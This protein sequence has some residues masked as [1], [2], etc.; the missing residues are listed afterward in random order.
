MSRRKLLIAGGLLA[1]GAYVYHRGLRFPRMGFTPPPLA[2]QVRLSNADVSFK[3]LIVN[4]SAAP[5]QPRFR[6]H[7]PEP[8]LTV[9][10]SQAPLTLTIDNIAQ[11]AV[12]NVQGL[13]AQL[14]LDEDIRGLQRTIRLP[15]SVAAEVTLRWEWPDSEQVRFAVIG[16]SGGLQELDWCLQRAA[17][18]NT[19]FLLHMGDFNYSEGE[20]DLAIEKFN[21]AQIPV[22]VSIGNHDFNQSGLIYQQFLDE[23]A[24]LNHSFI[25]A[26]SRFTNLDTAADFFPVSTGNRGRLLHS[27]LQ[28]QTEVSDHVAFSHS[29]FKDT[30]PG[31][32]HDI[33]GGG[34]IA[35]L[36]DMLSQLGVEDYLC[37]HVHRSSEIETHG[38]RQWI[39]GE[40]LGFEDIRNK[41]KVAQILLGE[42]QVGKKIQY[43]W[44]P[45]EMPWHLQHSPTHIEK[46]KKEL[47]ASMLEWYRQKTRL[48]ES[49]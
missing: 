10:G 45:L 20:Y 40:G 8:L 44:A 15:A 34:E 23:I 26:G 36:A 14:S 5:E 18:L 27:L 22:Y 32:D 11:H 7:E 49:G 16:D 6:A 2:N 1:G 12:L 42:A 3:G 28:D 30:R 29:P 24:P 13:P 46:I 43:Q 31:K 37:G 48:A 41:K 17:D 33:G 35:W 39:A 4:R 38:L 47:P 25:I 21:N 19:Q 9:H